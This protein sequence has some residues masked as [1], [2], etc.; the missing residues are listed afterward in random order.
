MTSSRGARESAEAAL[1]STQVGAWANRLACVLLVVLL[2][3]IYLATLYPGVRAG[4]SAELQW[5]CA[6]LGVCHPPGYALEVVVGKLFSVLPIGSCVAWRINFMQAVCGVV[7]CLA[8]YGALRRLTGQIPPGLVAAMTLA[9]STIY[10][11]HGTAAEVYVFYSMFLLLGVYTAVRFLT[12]DK[13]GWFFLTALL[14]GICV[15][16]R[17]SEVLILPALAGLWLGFHGRVRLSLGRIAAAVLVGVLPFVFSVCFYMVRENPALLHAR[18]DALRDEILE[19]GTPFPKL[20]FS[21]RLRE[22]IS[23]SVGLKG[24]GR[25]DFTAFSWRRVGWDLNKYAWLLSGVGAF[26]DRFS[27]VDT[28]NDPVVA[29]RQREQ[30]RGTSI[31]A[32]G[33]L[34]ALVGITRWRRQ[35]GAVLLGVWLFVGNLIFYL[36][37]HPVDNLH[38]TIPGLAG[39]AVLIGLGV[40]TRP[41]G[42]AV[43]TR[44]RGKSLVYQAA[45]FMVPGFLLVG[46]YGVV[47][48]R[49]PEVR[50]HLALGALIKKTPLPDKPAIIAMYSRA[51]TLRCLYWVDAGRTDVRVLIFRERFGREEL[52]R[53]VTGL[54]AGGYTVLFGTEAISQEETKRM[55]ARWTPRELIDVGLFRVFP[56]GAGQR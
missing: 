41:V 1:G 10:W 17:P 24:A 40:S 54:R 48:S 22:A 16:G 9:F 52:Q 55:L 4:D 12:S 14:L 47:D 18:D 21:Q 28:R 19:V 13:A 15:G 32:I 33:V 34:L 27:E 46:N 38:F 44:P 43:R 37:M 51:Q 42:S 7:G 23:Y 20:P 39:L 36:Y 30:G 25:E 49:T 31:S 8:L 50:E 35:R 53:M 3:G 2:G 5:M 26:G 45:C 11:R 6:L 56:P 29:F